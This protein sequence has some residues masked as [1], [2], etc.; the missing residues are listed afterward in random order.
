MCTRVSELSLRP[1]GRLPALIPRYTAAL[2]QDRTVLYTLGSR[3]EGNF[4]RGSE[5][6]GGKSWDRPVERGRVGWM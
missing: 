2:L 1:A 3:R 6:T 4:M 5:W